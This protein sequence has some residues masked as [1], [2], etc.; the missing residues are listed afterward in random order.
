MVRLSLLLLS[1]LLFPVKGSGATG[2]SNTNAVYLPSIKSVEFYNRKVE[3]SLPVL[4]LGST[5]QLLL[6]FDDLRGG[7]RNFTYTAE[8]CDAGWTSSRLSP[9]EYLSGFTEDRIVDVRYSINTLQKYSHYELTLPGLGITPKISGNYIL[10]VYEDSDPSKPVLSRR[11]YVVAPAARISITLSPSNNLSQRD[12]NQKIS[13]EITT[14][15]PVQNPYQDIRVLVMQNERDD[16]AQWAGPPTFIR[17]NTLIYSDM[18]RLDFKG[19]A[20]FRRFDTRSLRFQSEQVARITRDS[21][22]AVQLVTDMADDGRAYTA[23]LDQNGRFLVF[24]QNGRDSKTDAD[25]SRMRFTL[26]AQPA[27]GAGAAYIVGKFNGYA[28]NEENRMSYDPSRQLFT[29]SILLKQGVFDYHYVWASADGKN[30][31]DVSFDGS[32]YTTMNSYQVLVYFRQPGARWDELI[33]FAVT[34]SRR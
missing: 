22:N 6:A 27:D 28:L 33:G 19:G 13:L 26:S 20:E 1:L 15:K 34:D 24:N 4:T 16:N 18:N 29:A 2:F 31:Q 10:K 12:R 23:N 30:I 25:Y 11:F 7:S 3:Q 8:H 9:L 14:G 21:V 32:Y 17:Q 5:D